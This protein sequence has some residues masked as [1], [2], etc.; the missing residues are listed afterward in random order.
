MCQV[1]TEI[2]SKLVNHFHLMIQIK[3]HASPS[4]L[5]SFNELKEQRQI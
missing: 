4:G 5:L 1:M 3:T 2:L